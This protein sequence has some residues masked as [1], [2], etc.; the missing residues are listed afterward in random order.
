M[1]LPDVALAKFIDYLVQLAM[2]ILSKFHGDRIG[3]TVEYLEL[4]ILSMVS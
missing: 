3:I 4:H 1:T 2:R